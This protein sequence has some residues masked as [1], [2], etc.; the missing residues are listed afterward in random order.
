MSIL[1]RGHLTFTATSPS[2]QS[3]TL[4]GVDISRAIKAIT[5]TADAGQL[6]YVTVEWEAVAHHHGDQP[7][8]QG[9]EVA[10]RMLCGGVAHSGTGY[11]VSVT[12]HAMGAVVEICGTSELVEESS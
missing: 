12:P 4:D 11:V 5:V 6:P 3:V 2:R 10:V 8:P 1:A 9:A 7:P